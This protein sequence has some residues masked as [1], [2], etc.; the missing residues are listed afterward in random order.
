ML[1]LNFLLT[2]LIEFIIF[3][4]LL[5]KDY[6]KMAFYVLLVNL[7][8]WPLAN[9]IYGSWNHLV[10]IELGVFFIEGVIIHFLFEMNWRK[11]FFISFIA[12]FVSALTGFLIYPLVI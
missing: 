7:F 11:T 1:L 3:V 10:V 8:S 6:F 2:F 12:N 5:R 4:L 9:F